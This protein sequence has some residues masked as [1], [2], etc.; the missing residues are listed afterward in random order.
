MHSST[1]ACWASWLTMTWCALSIWHQP[2]IIYR[3]KSAGLS[4]VMLENNIPAVLPGSENN[5]AESDNKQSD[6][7]FK[8]DIAKAVLVLV[9]QE[10]QK[11][12]K[13]TRKL[14]WPSQKVQRNKR[15]TQHILNLL[16]QHSC[17]DVHLFD[18]ASESV[19]S[20]DTAN[21]IVAVPV[22]K[23]KQYALSSI[24]THGVADGRKPQDSTTNLLKVPLLMLS[25]SVLPIRVIQQA[26]DSILHFRL[27]T[28]DLLQALK[29][30]L[31]ACLR[32][33]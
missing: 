10:Q 7:L 26:A 28:K 25:I 8:T 17:S 27:L 6:C 11:H 31:L 33:E 30:T 16:V 15:N 20:T 23:S 3:I 12:A 14:G 2:G 9:C 32:C 5:A 4:R 21:W 22:S 24:K 13:Y 18:H 29:Y 19:H 1:T